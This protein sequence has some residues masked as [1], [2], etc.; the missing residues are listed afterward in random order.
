M[1]DFG[2]I[3]IHS[4]TLWGMDDGARDIDTSV[5]LCRIAHEQIISF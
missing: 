3:D 4:H 1:L 5:E 2:Y